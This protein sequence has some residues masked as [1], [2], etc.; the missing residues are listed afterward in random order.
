MGWKAWRIFHRVF[1]ALVIDAV[2]LSAAGVHILAAPGVSSKRER[3]PPLPNQATLQD[4]QPEALLVEP[5]FSNR[6][7]AGLLPTA[8]LLTQLDRN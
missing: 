4:H 5:A 8:I 7:F 3:L 1:L 2:S 6:G